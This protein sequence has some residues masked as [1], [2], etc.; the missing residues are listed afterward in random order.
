MN[1]S[2]T[3]GGG[4]VTNNSQLI[5][6][7][8]DSH[9]VTNAIA[10]GG[11]LL[12]RRGETTLLNT[13]VTNTRLYVL[14][15]Y[16]P[17]G[18]AILNISNSFVDIKATTYNNCSIGL[19]T[20]TATTGIVNMVSGMLRATNELWIA[21]GAAGNS[22]GV[23]NL[24]GGDILVH[25][26][27][28]VGCGNGGVNNY[29][30]LN[31]S[32]GTWSNIGPNHVSIASFVGNT[33][34]VTVS[35]GRLYAQNN[36]YVAEGGVGYLNVSGGTVEPNVL[37]IGQVAGGNGRVDIS[38]GS[39]TSRT[40]VL[41]GNAANTIATIV[42]TGGVLVATTQLILGNAANTIATLYQSGG[43]ITANGGDDMLAADTGAY[44]YVHSSAGTFTVNQNFQI[45]SRGIGEMDILG[46][47]AATAGAGY[48]VVGRYVGARGVLDVSGGSF[49]H[50]VA[51]T[52]L[53]IGEQGYGIVN[54]RG[55]GTVT[56]HSAR[57]ADGLRI[58]HNLGTGIVSIA[59]GGTVIAPAV[60]R[61]ADARNIG[62]LNF[63]GGT[64]RAN[65][66]NVAFM[67]NLSAAN[68][69][70]AGAKL[71]DGGFAITIAQPLLA[72]SG[73]GIT[74][75]PVLTG[76]AGATKARP[77]SRSSAAAAATPPHSRRLTSPSWSADQ[78]PHDGPR[79]R[80]HQLP[81]HHA[82]RRRICHRSN[83]RNAGL[84]RQHIRRPH[85]AW[86]GFV[87]ACNGFR[88][89]IPARQP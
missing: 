36:I 46:T 19:S 47:S 25:S 61:A 6:N 37:S 33:G 79:H 71:D 78:H 42:Q 85:E 5:F 1:A 9:V 82:C 24:I 8:P 21:A 30:E 39:I 2:G 87:Y 50:N 48:P 27:T 64:L 89:R 74:N 34:R 58:A 68:I 28:A 88:I 67:P 14:D 75:I 73:Q 44:A 45:G 69:H 15:S 65:N 62:T 59:T 72:P 81:R 49:T 57:T 40:T 52:F 60:S 12:A 17:S 51:G 22:R 35:G 54:V 55:S 70:S 10:G 7:R 13:T 84:D 83:A 16:I 86:R 29:G 41:A 20:N 66:N 18:N 26:W 53:I 76:G 43:S 80:L 3:L 38:G 4:N 11:Q 31:I 77:M 32:G 56:V 63:N 23:I